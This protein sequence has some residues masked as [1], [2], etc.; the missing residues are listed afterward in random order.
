MNPIPWES[1]GRQLTL[2]IIIDDLSIKIIYFLF[3]VLGSAAWQWSDL[4]AAL[5][6]SN[7]QWGQIHFEFPISNQNRS[8]F[9]KFITE[10]SSRKWRI[11]IQTSIWNRPG[12]QKFI[13]ESGKF[14]FLC[15]PP[16]QISIQGANKNQAEFQKG[17]GKR[18]SN[19]LV[20]SQKPNTVFPHIV[21]AETILFSIWKSKG[22]ST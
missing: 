15:V 9:K 8:V 13:A 21:S 11:W 20:S 1:F 14:T 12:I 4:M 22:H 17:I 7:V 10:S 19:F 2:F 5:V 18:F 3:S 6:S 16:T